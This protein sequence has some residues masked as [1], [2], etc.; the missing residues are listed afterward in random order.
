VKLGSLG[1]KKEL[2]LKQRVVFKGKI[3]SKW[4]LT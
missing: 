3:K 1:E 4:D 2:L